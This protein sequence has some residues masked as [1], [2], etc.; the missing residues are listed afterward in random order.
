MKI[1][2]CDIAKNVDFGDF[3]FIKFLRRIVSVAPQSD[4][5]SDICIKKL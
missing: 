5:S 2:T 1:L 3:L 4:F